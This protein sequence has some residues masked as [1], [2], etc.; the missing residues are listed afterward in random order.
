MT[1]DLMKQIID[2]AKSRTEDVY[3]VALEKLRQIN[4]AW[5]AYCT[6]TKERRNL[7]VILVPFCLV[8]TEDGER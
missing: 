3:Q 2:L 5:A 6:W 7:L 8:D 4:S 1:E